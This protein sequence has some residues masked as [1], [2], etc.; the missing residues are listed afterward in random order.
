M[1]ELKQNAD[2]CIV[3]RFIIRSSSPAVFLITKK[4]QVRNGYTILVGNF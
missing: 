3:R 2:G 4:R 1:P